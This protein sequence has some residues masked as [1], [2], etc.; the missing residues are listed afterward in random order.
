MENLFSKISSQTGVLK[1][2]AA[3][4]PEYL[5]ESLPGRESELKEIAA[6]LNPVLKGGKPYS[7]LLHGRTGT[8]KTSCAKY[9]FK[10]M[11]EYSARAKAVYINCWEK[12]TRQSILSE[13]CESVGEAMPRR[14]LAS[15]E[16]FARIVQAV[17]HEN[18]A[19]I[20]ALDEIDRLLVRR[21]E[22]ILYDLLRGEEN[23]G[24]RF[25]VVGITNNYEACL[26]VD[27]RIRSSFMSKQV[28]FKPYSP[29]ELKKI[30]EDRIKIAFAPNSCPPT[31]VSL[32]A[33]HGA[34]AGGDARIALETLWMAARNA[35]NRGGHAITEA[36]VKKAAH[37]K[38]VMRLKQA[39]DSLSGIER[40]VLEEV[41]RAG[42]E[43][44]S[45]ELYGKLSKKT[46]ET[47]RNIR[48]AL[49]S[50]EGKGL[51]ELELMTPKEGG[52]TRRISLTE[53]TK[54]ID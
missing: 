42:G 32:C 26:K 17:K 46:N 33:A 9:V 38:S 31:I 3:L 14:G 2:E 49:S 52:R 51:L 35:E 12:T 37:E 45:G 41:K 15:D 18:I 21:E 47:E 19:L 43:I 34:K 25:G 11:Q 29:I 54:L 5:P 13:L 7:L 16:L 48:N 4:L 30:L 20:V 44:R 23:Y 6:A 53:F 24:A 36:D 8:G 50:L 39:L 27:D 28:L 40:L 1:Q 10:Q 22:R